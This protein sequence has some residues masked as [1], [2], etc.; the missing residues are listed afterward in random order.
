MEL[1][2]LVLPSTS[3]SK[4]LLTRGRSDTVLGAELV[5]QTFGV[6]GLLDDALFVVL[7]DGS[8]Q[9]VVVHCWAILSLA[10]KSRDAS[11]VLNLKDS[12]KNKNMKLFREIFLWFHL[13]KSIKLLIMIFRA[14]ILLLAEFCSQQRLEIVKIQS[15]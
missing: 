6:V 10:P 13:N 14:H 1:L 8:R 7:A 12:C 3:G 5:D 4:L 9:L 11:G 15:W 2:L